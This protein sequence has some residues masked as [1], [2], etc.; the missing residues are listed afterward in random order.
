MKKKATGTDP[1]Y[2]YAMENAAL[3]GMELRPQVMEYLRQK[4]KVA[5]LAKQLQ[6][7]AA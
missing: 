4:V 1:T 2:I 3:C 7:T 5:K 6:E